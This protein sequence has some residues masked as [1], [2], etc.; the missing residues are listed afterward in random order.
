M[1]TTLLTT[2]TRSERY[3]Y[4]SNVNI[5]FPVLKPVSFEVILFFHALSFC[6]HEELACK[7]IEKEIIPCNPE[8]GNRIG[9]FFQLL[10]TAWSRLATA[11]AFANVSE[12]VSP[13]MVFHG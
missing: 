7:E 6:V 4:R 8:S 11:A 3:E 9:Y 13:Y 12:M 5:N 10:V 1:R 2:V